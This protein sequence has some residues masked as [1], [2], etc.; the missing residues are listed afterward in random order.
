M[1]SEV[2]SNPIRVRRIIEQRIQ[3]PEALLAL[4]LREMRIIKK[5]P[6]SKKWGKEKGKQREQ[7]VQPLRT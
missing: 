4:V 5:I 3:A 1:L 6:D 7:S 2:D